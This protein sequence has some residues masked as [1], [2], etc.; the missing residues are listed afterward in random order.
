[1]QWKVVCWMLLWSSCD[2]VSSPCRWW[3]SCSKRA[4]KIPNA[5]KLQM[6]TDSLPG[7]TLDPMVGLEVESSLRHLLPW[8]QRFDDT[9]QDGTLGF[10]RPKQLVAAAVLA[11]FVVAGL[12]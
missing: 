6:V 12:G 9:L 10:E 11:A 5:E 7:W 8:Y 4:L 3:G 2:D 1:M